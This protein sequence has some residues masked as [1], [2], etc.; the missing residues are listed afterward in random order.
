[1]FAKSHTMA[2]LGLATAVTI[3]L[4][5]C[6][7]SPSAPTDVND[8]LRTPGAAAVVDDLRNLQ[9][10]TAP[11]HD[12][13]AAQAGGYTTKLT[14]CMTDPTGGMGYH[15]GKGASIDANVVAADPEVLLYE[16]KADGSL[17]LVGVEYI[18]PFTAWT[19]ATPPTLY[20]QTFKRNEGFQLWALHAWVW[21]ANPSGVFADWNP[22]VGC[23]G[24]AKTMSHHGH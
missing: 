9:T 1:M 6:G 20:G 4:V 21:K 11:Y 3:A 2:A 15:Y 22:N 7:K 23:A 14:E 8:P 10:V 18:V 12:F 19:A 5:R 24:A 16:P 17:E 13:K